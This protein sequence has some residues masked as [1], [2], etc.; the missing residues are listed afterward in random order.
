MYEEFFALN[1]R[2]F[3]A[4]PRT[5]LYFPSRIVEP[6]RQML[7][8]TIE[9]AEGAS[10]IVGPAGTGKTLL[11]RMLAEKFRGRFDVALLTNGRLPS[12]RALL[13]A[14][15]FELGMPYRRLDEGELRLSLLDR[16]QPGASASEGLLLIV[17]EAH[18]LP[19]RLLEEVRLITDFMRQGSPRVRLVLAGAAALEER[20][21]AP[22]LNSLQ[23][24]ITARAY[25]EALDRQ[26]TYAYVRHQLSACGVEPSAVFTDA[27][28]EA[29]YR[30]G[31]GLP[32]LVN[33][34]CDHALIMACAGE[35][36]PVDAAGIEEAWSDLQQLPTPWSEAPGYSDPTAVSD[37]SVVE[38]GLLDDAGPLDDAVGASRRPNA[39]P[40]AAAIPE[41]T[42]EAD[43]VLPVDLERETDEKLSELESHLADWATD[44]VPVVAKQPE[45]EL[46]LTEQ[47]R[48]P[49]AEDFVEEVT[50]V[51]RYAE[52]ERSCP[53]PR[54][55]VYSA[56]GRALSSLLEARRTD[57][58]AATPP[59]ADVAPTRSESPTQ[60][61]AV[62]RPVLRPQP[63]A[64]RA[65]IVEFPGVDAVEP[66]ELT[67]TS[68][69]TSGDADMIIVEDEAHETLRGSE[70][71]VVRKQEYRQL[72]ARLR[73]G[74]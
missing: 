25:L 43:E 68:R 67:I 4:A 2:P 24:R 71:V 48:D 22:R 12:R 73:R 62:P 64:V 49:F 15:L 40:I 6:A 58:P 45:V 52:A 63:P 46:M 54:V 3:T 37:D 17:D 69:R 7:E 27:A 53:A 74:S 19:L 65:P 59:V 42:V 31:D 57:R 32:R 21:T 29:I 16:L 44:Y 55:Q 28:L 26:E 66:E 39:S 30:A 13:Q 38:F 41:A 9:R 47:R 72:F 11:C 20:L 1:E 56:E 10:L 60:T 23:Q 35:V 70:A 36:K 5:E 18:M 34:I 51:D 33:Q 50:I 14:I 8:R 61:G